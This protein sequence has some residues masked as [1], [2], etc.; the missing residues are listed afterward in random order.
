MDDI[1]ALLLA[2]STSPED[3]QVLMLSLQFG[4]VDVQKYD[5]LIVAGAAFNQPMSQYRR[6]RLTPNS[7]L[8]NVVSLFHFIEKEQAWRKE[9]GRP[10][11]FEALKVTKPIGIVL[12]TF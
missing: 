8:R 2:F 10:E 7:C 9:H 4:N 3:L 5:A 6:G 11:G 1:L 12:Y